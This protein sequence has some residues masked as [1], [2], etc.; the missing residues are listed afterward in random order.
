[1]VRDVLDDLERDFGGVV[2]ARREY[3]RESGKHDPGGHAPARLPQGAHALMESSSTSKIR[4]EPPGM[5]P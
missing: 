4:I 1:M 5:T 3:P 2:S